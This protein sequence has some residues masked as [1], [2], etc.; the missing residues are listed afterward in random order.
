MQVLCAT[1]SSA[2]SAPLDARRNHQAKTAMLGVMTQLQEMRAVCGTENAFRDL[3]DPQPSALGI[4][5]QSSHT[6]DCLQYRVPP[7]LQHPPSA[8]CGTPWARDDQAL[9]Y[10]HLLS[11][12]KADGIRAHKK[13]ANGSRS[14]EDSVAIQV[15]PEPAELA[16]KLHL[17]CL[18]A[19]FAGRENLLYPPVELQH[20]HATLDILHS[21]TK[22]SLPGMIESICRNQRVGLVM[23]DPPSTEH[24]C[25][26]R[27]RMPADSVVKIFQACSK[28][29]E[30]A[31][32]PAWTEDSDDDVEDDD[33]ASAE[34][35]NDWVFF[36]YLPRQCSWPPPELDPGTY[37]EIVLL[38]VSQVLAS[39]IHYAQ[40]VCMQAALCR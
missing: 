14:A 33:A 8:F 26:D 5:M 6:V 30:A 20:T 18:A 39:V 22:G 38:P 35:P 23:V 36:S 21:L 40:S 37:R 29:F 9:G 25:L 13:A 28:A 16:A 19:R 27:P 31:P 2:H 17:S 15:G 11:D 3:L 10:P 32:T 7:E 1:I 4:I 12:A 24:I 34:Q